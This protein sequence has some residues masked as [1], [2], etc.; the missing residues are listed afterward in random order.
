MSTLAEFA[1]ISRVELA[2]E[3]EKVSMVK[4]YLQDVKVTE[5]EILNLASG[6][7]CGDYSRVV[8]T[9]FEW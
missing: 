1:H 5:E 9:G 6:V 4:V 3:S 2:Q 8:N 7:W